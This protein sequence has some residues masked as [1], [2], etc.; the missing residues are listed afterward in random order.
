[1]AYPIHLNLKYHNIHDEPVIVSTNVSREIRIYKDLKRDHKEEKGKAVEINVGSP[2][3]HSR[4]MVIWTLKGKE[5]HSDH[6]FA[7]KEFGW[8]FTPTTMSPTNGLNNQ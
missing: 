4:D 5:N 8:K 2:I 1:M 3:R 7:G 6:E